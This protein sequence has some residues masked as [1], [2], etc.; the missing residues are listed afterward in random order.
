[1]KGHR[2]KGAARPTP[3]VD[4][5]LFSQSSFGLHSLLWLVRSGVRRIRHGRDVPRS[6]RGGREYVRFDKLHRSLHMVVIVSFLMIGS[7]LAG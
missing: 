4:P 1:M 2:E 7:A 5:E 6:E 3:F